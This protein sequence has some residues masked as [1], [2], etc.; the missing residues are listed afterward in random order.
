MDKPT[1]IALLA[2]TGILLCLIGPLSIDQTYANP[3]GQTQVPVPSDAKAPV[4][5]IEA[6]KNN[7]QITD[8]ELTL[9]FNITEPQPEAQDFKM[10]LCEV[11][12]ITDWQNVEVTFVSP[13]VERNYP[14]T[15][16]FSGKLANIPT[17]PHSIT[18]STTGY[19]YNASYMNLNF[20]LLNATATVYFENTCTTPSN[21]ILPK[22]D[23]LNL[24][25]QTPITMFLNFTINKPV[26]W[27]AY[28]INDRP[29]IAIT[30]NETIIPEIGNNTL[31]LYV[32]DT[33]GI[34]TSETINFLLS[35]ATPKPYSPASPTSD[36]TLQPTATLNSTPSAEAS[37]SPVPEVPAWLIL[38]VALAMVAAAV[39][40]RKKLKP[41]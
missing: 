24:T 8:N 20:Y 13:N 32:V 17:G 5:T 3:I 36:P 18:V 19:F 40:M 6:P 30:G 4:V 21:I 29:T 14:T 11:H 33:D 27:M 39:A 9:T 35:V 23:N 28:G 26:R 1:F 15:F 12:Y 25:S 16:N 22:I 31:T 34:L 7:T 41:I 10:W 2:V 37:T 38:P